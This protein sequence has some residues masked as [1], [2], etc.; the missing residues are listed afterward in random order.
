MDRVQG[1]GEVARG[2]SHPTARCSWAFHTAG[3]PDR[4]PRHRPSCASGQG[5]C[6]GFPRCLLSSCVACEN[7]GSETVFYT[8]SYRV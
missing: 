2:P 8:C 1:A 5:C 4:C 7:R 3:S 6:E